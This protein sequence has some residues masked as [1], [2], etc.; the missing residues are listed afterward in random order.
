LTKRAGGRGWR[1][2]RLPA[3]RRGPVAKLSQRPRAPAASSRLRLAATPLG[4]HGNRRVAAQAIID[5]GW[6]AARECLD[7]LPPTQHTAN[8]ETASEA[9]IAPAVVLPWYRAAHRQRRLRATGFPWR[10]ILGHRAT[11][12]IACAK[13]LAS[14]GQRLRAKGS[15]TTGELFACATTYPAPIYAQV[16]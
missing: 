5:P 6:R 11:S 7:P 3:T 9:P 4:P 2:N 1:A 8:A 16:R 14:P 13:P 10:L 15:Y 12:P